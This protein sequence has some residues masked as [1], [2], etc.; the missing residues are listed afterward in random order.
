[1][2]KSLK[3][4]H[5]IVM[6]N[7]AF[8]LL[9]GGSLIFLL[10]EINGS[11]GKIEDQ[12][13]EVEK[14]NNLVKTQAEA[15]SSQKELLEVL[16]AAQQVS[17]RFQEMRFWYYDLAVRPKDTEVAKSAEDLRQ[18]LSTD[19]GEL[20]SSRPELV[21]QVR[22][23]IEK[24]IEEVVAAVEA[25]NAWDKV[26]GATH[27]DTARGH[28]ATVTQ[29]LG[30]FV[31]QI[32]ADASSAGTQ[33]TSQGE[34]L[35]QSGISVGE[36]ASD[37]K[38]N[39][40]RVQQVAAFVVIL[41]FVLGIIFTWL[42]IRAIL[43]PINILYRAM[44]EIERDSDLTRRIDV[45]SSDEIGI[46]ADALNK[47]LDRFH[48][49]VRQVADSAGKVAD[50]AEQTNKTIERTNTLMEDHKY[51]T[52]QLATAIHEVS[53][54]LQE[55]AKN[56]SAAAEAAT[57]SNVEANNGQRVV[58]QTIEAI[59]ALSN[60]VL[61]VTE[62][63][64]RLAKDSDNIGS[65]L[66]VIRGISDQTNLLALNASIEAARAGD[67]GRGFAVVADEVRTL[68]HRTS[69][70]TQEI[71]G[72]IERLQSG[73]S[74]AVQAIDKGRTRAT[75]GVSQAAKAGES[76]DSIAEAVSVINDLNTQIATATE[77]QST[78]ATNVN[79][80]IDNIT[81][82]VK[83]TLMGSRQTAVANNELLKLA[84]QLEDLIGQFRV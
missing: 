77:E 9:A 46:T 21:E 33:V 20:E 59:N 1:M 49:I 30:E 6:M 83:Q 7:M 70:S 31:A 19:L 76:L 11:S 80:N 28:A 63:I 27:L 55:V 47:M 48:S 62:V 56:T 16:N 34:A 35:R 44:E 64:Q 10:N 41:I 12:I 25:F 15:V 37:V 32:Q 61:Q 73:A 2:K 24:F 51:E 36:A 26:A 23:G 68:A 69:Q 75:A 72:M 53:A 66:D 5:K 43:R 22:P 39:N 45:H 17:N 14:Q 58:A 18:K 3:I 67:A 57:R 65:V 54:M 42:L 8:V 50:S 71:Q 13:A 74:L 81:E 79:R 38:D 82:V 4:A 40:E 84:A 29:S 78:V 52:D 60:E